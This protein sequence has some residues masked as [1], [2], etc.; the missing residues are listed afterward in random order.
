MAEE[1]DDKTEAATPRRREQAKERGE[2]AQSRDLTSTFI[3]LAA[4]GIAAST[5]G[6]DF[7]AALALEARGLWGGATIRPETLADYHALFLF[8][9]RKIAAVAA[10]PALVML[11][12]GILGPF[13]QIGPLFSSKSLAFRGDRIDPFKGLKRV[14]SPTKL[15]ELVKS[16]LKLAAV[17][18]ALAWVI[19]GSAEMIV[20]LVGEPVSRLLLILR[21]LSVKVSI[22]TIATLFVLAVLDYSWVRFQHERKLR[23]TRREV[24]D[25][26]KDREGSPELRSRIRSLQR[27]NS[28]LR[29]LA[30]AADADVIVRNPTHYAVALRY[31]RTKMGAPTVLAKGRNHIAL[32]IIDVGRENDVPIVENPAIARVLYRTTRV[33]HEIPE[34]LYETVAEIMAYVYRL[35]RARA[36]SWMTA[37]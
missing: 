33:G 16:L 11:L 21:S 27:D 29:M 18:G 3:L 32:R 25:E 22:A 9:L 14:F 10:G 8:L 4:L 35:D 2:V 23:M 28:R 34:S 24:R 7:A 36:S 13:L 15:F 26:L 37:S 31:E 19:S 1:K 30:E 20:G 6:A 5:L 17:G 12:A